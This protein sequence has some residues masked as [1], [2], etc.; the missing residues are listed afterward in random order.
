MRLDSLRASRN[1]AIPWPTSAAPLIWPCTLRCLDRRVVGVTR[2]PFGAAVV[3]L[4]RCR[5]VDQPPG[6]A[7]RRG[8]VRVHVV[9][10][11]A[12]AVEQASRRLAGQPHSEV[13]WLGT[14]R[15]HRGARAPARSSGSAPSS[16]LRSERSRRLSALAAACGAICVARPRAPCRCGPCARSLFPVGSPGLIAYGAHPGPIE[17]TRLHAPGNRHLIPGNGTSELLRPLPRSS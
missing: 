9:H 16:W 3:E 15:S 4:A 17:H 5:P 12:A 10:L 6:D 1:L 11:G 14:A 7:E 2:G 13:E 8:L